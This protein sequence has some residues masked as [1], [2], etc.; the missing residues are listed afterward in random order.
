MTAKSSQKNRVIVITGVTRG[1]GQ[2][3]AA[4][5]VEAEHT[6]IGCSRTATEVERL[7]KELGT[8]HD[9]ATVDVASDAA[10]GA[11]AWRVVS[12]F[13][14]PDLL[15][16]NAAVINQNSP[17]WEVSAEDFDRVT[18]VNINGVANCVRHFV[19]AM[20]S[21]GTGV[22]V[23]FSSGWGRSTS[24]EVAPYCATKWAIE[25]LTK[26]LAQELPDGMAAVPLNPGIINTEMLQ[27]CFGSSAKSY[28]TAEEWS[29]RAVPLLLKLGSKDNG[30]SL[31]V[32]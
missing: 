11:W 27:S 26:A 12:K 29:R 18:A 10:V 13:G 23:N 6:V 9:F 30:R 28:P 8:P 22:I 21:R 14:A 16:N 31:S 19:P 3:M 25:G 1:L 32:E 24:P 17:L 5:F 2:A 7:Q 4:R 20:I 15:L